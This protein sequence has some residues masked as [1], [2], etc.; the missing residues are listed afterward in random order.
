MATGEETA[1]QEIRDLIKEEL[2]PIKEETMPEKSEYCP[3]CGLPHNAKQ[4]LVNITTQLEI[5]KDR[6]QHDIEKTEA[7]NK[8]DEGWKATALSYQEHLNNPDGCS[9]PGSCN[10]SQAIKKS[11]D[12]AV[13]KHLTGMTRKD[14]LKAA[15]ITEPKNI[16]FSQNTS[17][18]TKKAVLAVVQG[19]FG[20]GK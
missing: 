2:K 11:N 18:Q 8:E 19:I 10:I 5:E 1:R 9:N 14:Y 15:G 4:E 17:E 20:D 7:T 12:R 13:A 6:H 3:T 16:K